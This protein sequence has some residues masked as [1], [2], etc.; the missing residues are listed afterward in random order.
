MWPT[1]GHEVTRGYFRALTRPRTAV[2]IQL[3]PTYFAGRT[4]APR[5]YER[6]LFIT[7]SSGL[8]DAIKPE[9][10]GRRWV[11]VRPTNFEKRYMFEVPSV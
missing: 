6:R 11:A 9:F 7:A 2:R 4:P 5:G 3:R 1:H 8:P 10:Q